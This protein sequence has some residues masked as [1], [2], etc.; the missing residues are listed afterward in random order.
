PDGISYYM[1]QNP[2]DRH[3]GAEAS[4]VNE[5][6]EAYDA[7][8]SNEA[9]ESFEASEVIELYWSI[10]SVVEW[11]D[12]NTAVYDTIPGSESPVYYIAFLDEGHTMEDALVNG[13]FSTVRLSSDQLIIE[14][15]PGYIFDG[16]DMLLVDLSENKTY[17]LG[18]WLDNP[19]CKGVN[20]GMI[21]YSNLPLNKNNI[22]KLT[23]PAKAVYNNAGGY[24]KYN[25]EYS[26]EL[27]MEGAVTFS[28]INNGDWAQAYIYE[29]TEKRI[30]NGYEDGTFRPNGLVTR[31]EFAKLMYL[32]L[33]LDQTW[34][35]SGVVV[36]QPFFVD[37][38]PDNWD[39][40]YVKYV[41]RYM[42]IYR[43]PDGSAYF[44]GHEA[45]AREDM[46]V[47]LVKALGLDSV[48][49]YDDTDVNEGLKGI[50]SD[51]ETI[52]PSL[53][54]F[55]LIAYRQ[56]LINGYPDGTFGAQKPIT[57]AEAAALLIKVLKSD[58]MEKTV[59]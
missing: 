35:Y 44:R 11:E 48:G 46:A 23:I 4:E 6:S 1:I 15:K 12:E 27:I 13:V 10:S 14:A 24:Y 22:Y 30:I 37:V 40:I 51:Y 21:I 41:S 7:S 3:I 29:L 5:A 58:V 32:A 31:S 9:S 26:T 2:Q 38:Y 19:D 25:A 57:R 45:A 16:S 20:S 54:K 52:S 42:T 53:R 8:E 33:Q 39:Y 28:D 59:F 36:D 49:G 34:D 17:E 43:T 50:F 47:A 56:N 18:I 55:V